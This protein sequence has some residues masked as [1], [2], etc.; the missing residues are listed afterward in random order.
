MCTMLH[1]ECS[2]PMSTSV[3]A[4]WNNTALEGAP[5]HKSGCQKQGRGRLIGR[6]GI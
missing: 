2:L 6:A 3:A 1:F 4:V 5:I